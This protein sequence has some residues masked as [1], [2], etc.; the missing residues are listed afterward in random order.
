MCARHGREDKD[1]REQ[2]ATGGGAV[3]QERN[4]A[5]AGGHPLAH[6]AGADNDCHQ[7][8]ATEAFGRKPRPQRCG[9]RGHGFDL[10]AS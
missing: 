2:T 3:G 7:Q 6:D 8:R 9:I 5:V 4:R 1:Q 10:P